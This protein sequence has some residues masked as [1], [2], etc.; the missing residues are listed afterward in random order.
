[1]IANSVGAIV[2]YQVDTANLAL[3]K[4]ILVWVLF[5]KMMKVRYETEKRSWYGATLYY[6]LLV[7]IGLQPVDFLSFIDILSRVSAYR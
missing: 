4:D 2:D 6:F 3:T 7:F 5:L 1:M